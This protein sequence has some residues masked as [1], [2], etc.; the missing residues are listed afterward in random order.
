M[1]TIHRD[2]YKCK[3]YDF[4]TFAIGSDSSAEYEQDKNDLEESSIEYKQVPIQ[5]KTSIKPN[6][7][8][9]SGYD[10]S[11]FSHN[12]M[13]DF[14]ADTWDLDAEKQI[15]T[16][17][18][19]TSIKL[20]A[21]GPDFIHSF[22]NPIVFEKIK[23]EN[24]VAVQSTESLPKKIPK[25][26]K[27]LLK[28]ISIPQVFGIYGGY[29]PNSY[30]YECNLIEAN[31]TSEYFSVIVGASTREVKIEKIK[32][33]SIQ[34]LGEKS[35]NGIRSKI[36]LD[37]KKKL[38]AISEEKID[39]ISNDFSEPKDISNSQFESAK[40]KDLS[41]DIVI[42]SDIQQGPSKSIKPPHIV[43]SSKDEYNQNLLINSQLTKNNNDQLINTNEAKIIDISKNLVSKIDDIKNQ[44]GNNAQ[45]NKISRNDDTEALS[46]IVNKSKSLNGKSFNNNL[47]NIKT[48]IMTKSK[49]DNAEITWTK[50]K[51]KKFL[52]NQDQ[53]NKTQGLEFS[54]LDNNSKYSLPI[55]FYA[56]KTA[57]V[58]IKGF[59]TRAKSLTLRL[60]E[61]NNAQKIPTFNLTDF[62]NEIIKKS[63]N[64]LQE[65]SLPKE[66]K[67]SEIKTL[68]VLEVPKIVTPKKTVKV[69]NQQIEKADNNIN[70]KI[71]AEI[72]RKKSRLVSAKN[73]LTK[74]FKTL[75]KVTS[76]SQLVN[77]IS[78][79]KKPEN[80][81]PIKQINNKTS[82]VFNTQNTEKTDDKS[83][84]NRINEKKSM[85]KSI[86]KKSFSY[87]TKS[88]KISSDKKNKARDSIP[89]IG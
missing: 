5:E 74:P 28:K 20:Y 82:E 10:N 11:S 55:D 15:I 62:K 2:I 48:E 43:A 72:T 40:N 14:I 8:Q 84:E 54:N 65:K 59:K 71:S 35:S 13:I 19:D 83:A 79:S 7:P 58:N 44:S 25:P 70:S 4:N 21:T 46:N 34:I 51:S 39:E 31:S 22:T 32:G 57:S 9:N 1:A 24:A 3:E 38:D 89:I 23:A 69:N 75:N 53:F 42:H 87:F 76:V 86:S 36:E 27:A 80:D 17:V 26:K 29:E 47:Q 77:K 88:M 56:E 6:Q 66:H 37:D 60:D 41:K 18:V 73:I 16:P 30:D 68:E 45:D 50:G 49:S 12:E 63:Q 52:Q 64:D 67:A 33:N 85:Y 78:S 61:N 81:I